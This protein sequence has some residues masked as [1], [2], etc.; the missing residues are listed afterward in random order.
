M[1]IEIGTK[2]ILTYW[3][4]VFSPM[5][6]KKDPEIYISKDVGEEALTNKWMAQVC[7]VLFNP[8][9]HGCSSPLYYASSH[10][11]CHIVNLCGE[12]Y[13]FFSFYSQSIYCYSF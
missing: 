7:P 12:I 3:V 2:T 11:A 5:K 6:Q 4:F 10:Y 1:L 8:K 9:A 13:F